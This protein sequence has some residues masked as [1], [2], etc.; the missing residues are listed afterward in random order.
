VTADRIDVVS[1]C[2]TVDLPAVVEDTK[3]DP[4][5]ATVITVVTPPA[6]PVVEAHS[7]APPARFAAKL[8]YSYAAPLKLTALELSGVSD[9]TVVLSAKGLK[10]KRYTHVSGRL[11]L[12]KKRTFKSGAVITVT[13]SKPGYVTEIRT[14][15]LRARKKPVL[16]TLCQPPGAAKPAAC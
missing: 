5:P 16:K 14:L 15:T 10:T 4:P 6:H 12:L 1:G 8:A 9:A 3:N 13:L 2:E 7:V 11:K